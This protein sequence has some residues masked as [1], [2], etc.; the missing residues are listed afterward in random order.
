LNIRPFPWAR[1]EPQGLDQ[2]SAAFFVAGASLVLRAAASAKILRRREEE[3]TLRDAE[4]LAVAEDMGPAGSLHRL[5]RTL[6]S[7]DA[8]PDAT[9]PG[10]DFE[11]CI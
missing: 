10:D 5:W 1:L 4:H 8:R 9:E 2:G 3:A 11:A 6:A 7:K